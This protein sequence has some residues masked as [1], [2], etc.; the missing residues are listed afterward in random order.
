MCG[1]T[2]KASDHEVGL[3]RKPRHPGRRAAA[4]PETHNTGLWNMVPG[5]PLRG[6]RNNAS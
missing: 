1:S 4:S 6:I 2:G 3:H 5:L